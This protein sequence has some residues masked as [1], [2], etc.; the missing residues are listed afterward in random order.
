MNVCAVCAV[1]V[2][3]KEASSGPMNDVLIKIRGMAPPLV[4]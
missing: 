3:V 1:C 4:L 2:C